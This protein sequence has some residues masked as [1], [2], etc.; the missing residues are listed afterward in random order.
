MSIRDVLEPAISYADNGF[1]VL[2]QMSAAITVV[3]SLFR[4]EWLASAA[5]WLPDGE[6]PRPGSILRNPTLAATYRRV[7]S[8]AE[9]S[10]SGREQQIDAA[11][12]IFY[13]GFVAD[14]IDRA[15]KTAFMDSSGEPHSGLLSGND[16]ANWRPAQ[17]DPISFAYH[18]VTV[19]KPAPW[20]QGLVFL[21]QLSIL[22]G[23]ELAASGFMSAYHVHSVI[24]TAKLAFADRE[25]W[26]GDPRFA[27]DLSPALLNAEYA[28]SRR[29]M[30]STMAS[31][32]MRPGSPGGRIPRLPRIGLI[33]TATGHWT[34]AGLQ[35]IAERQTLG[36]GDTCQIDVVDKHGNFVAA[37]P[38]GGWLQSSPTLPALG[39]CLG[40]RAQ[41]FNLED[42]HPNA[43]APG[44]RPRTTLSPSLA[45]KNGQPWLAFGTPGG[46]QQD[47]WT[48]QFFLA[49]LDFGLGLQEAI[50]ASMFHTEQLIS[51]FEPHEI[52]PGRLVIEESVDPALINL[53]RELGHD[54]ALV[55]RWSLGRVCVVGRDIS[56]GQLIAAADSRGMQAYAAGR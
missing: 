19:C 42:G 45:L 6:P 21:Q 28:T 56:S 36:K 25:A 27:E 11:L 39:F 35:S 18:G 17:E 26:Y 14:E 46:D 23:L 15:T 54:V 55:N 5:I 4:E 9:G 30:I 43:L 48:M 16:L 20:S 8:E 33:Q 3:E 22:E 41:M 31:E 12:A 34:G 52:H 29:Q 53:L 50:D 24:E 1:S 32:E 37:T 44:K 40:T 51:S 47:Q 13:Q 7:L 49:H 10:A 2:P 38:S